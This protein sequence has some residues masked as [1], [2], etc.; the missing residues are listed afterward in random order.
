VSQGL[1]QGRVFG[2]THALRGGTPTGQRP[3]RSHGRTTP[4]DNRRH[5]GLS[6]QVPKVPT[7]ASRRRTRPTAGVQAPRGTAP[8][9]SPVLTET[10]TG[11]GY[12]APIPTSSTPADPL[13]PFVVDP[14]PRVCGLVRGWR[15]GSSRAVPHNRPWSRSPGPSPSRR[16]GGRQPGSRRAV[17]DAHSITERNLSV[18]IQRRLGYIRERRA[19]P[20]ILRDNVGGAVRWV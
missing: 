15:L 10:L 1:G 8:G 2:R 20:V 18:P 4:S 9:P 7:G 13:S 19:T 17:A 14:R 11:K 16:L 3:S 5:P 12:D 6:H